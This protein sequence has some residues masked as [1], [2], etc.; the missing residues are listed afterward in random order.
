MIRA[1]EWDLA[2]RFIMCPFFP[3]EYRINCEYRFV[4]WC[5]RFT[6]MTLARLIR[7][8][9]EIWPATD[10]LDRIRKITKV[11]WL[12]YD[13]G[14]YDSIIPTTYYRTQ[15]ELWGK[16]PFYEL[17]PGSNFKHGD[18][19]AEN[20]EWRAYDFYGETEED[21]EWY[22]ENRLFRTNNHKSFERL[23]YHGDSLDPFLQDDSAIRGHMF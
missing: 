21:K 12:L 17:H 18:L 4:P 23:I 22:A 6:P 1:G 3:V 19:R 9:A 15:R 14:G 20:V 8:R 2:E 11:M 7:F 13:H 5:K 16:E 10:K